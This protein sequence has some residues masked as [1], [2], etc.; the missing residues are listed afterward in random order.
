MANQVGVKEAADL[1]LR[2]HSEQS[3][4]AHCRSGRLHVREWQPKRRDPTS[5]VNKRPLESQLPPL[6]DMDHY[7]A[8]RRQQSPTDHQQSHAAASS[9]GQDRCVI[10]ITPTS[11]TTSGLPLR[12]DTSVN[13]SYDDTRSS[14]AARVD[15]VDH[16]QPLAA[17]GKESQDYGVIQTPPMPVTTPATTGGLSLR[18][19]SPTIDRADDVEGPGAVPVDSAVGHYHQQPHVVASTE[20]QDRGVIQS[21]PVPRMACR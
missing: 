18:G 9:D 15:R 7:P 21:P 17:A 16:Q 13:D 2:K 12:G 14:D 11:V 8:L 1:A 19:N 3:R 6:A 5:E 10:E 4:T 20:D